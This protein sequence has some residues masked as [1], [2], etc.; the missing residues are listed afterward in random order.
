MIDPAHY[1]HA[2][3]YGPTDNKSNSGRTDDTSAREALEREVAKVASESVHR[4][5]ELYAAACS[6]RQL[7]AGGLLD[8]TEVLNRL[9]G[10]ATNNGSVKVDGAD[11]VDETIASGLGAGKQHPPGAPERNQSRAR[12]RHDKAFSNADATA[13]FSCCADV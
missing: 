13:E 12:R 4:I 9:Y 5:T 11:V 1:F 7:V 2:E 6:L 10:A 3:E 8:K